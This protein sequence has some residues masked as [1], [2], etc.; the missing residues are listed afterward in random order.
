MTVLQFGEIYIFI[1]IS[2]HIVKKIIFAEV[3]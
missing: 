3:F 2:I 1:L